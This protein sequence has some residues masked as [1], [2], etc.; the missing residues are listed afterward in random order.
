MVILG[1]A[2]KAEKLKVSMER[3]Q[4]WNDISR[5]IVTM[6]SLQGQGGQGGPSILAL[7]T[8]TFLVSF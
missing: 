2:M 5:R 4:I 3:Y 7:L 6:M 1:E 8:M